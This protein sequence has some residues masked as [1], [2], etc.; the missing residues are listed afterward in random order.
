MAK[1]YFIAVI[2]LIAPL[3]LSLPEDRDE[4][5]EI[6]ADN[7]VINEKESR[8]EYSGAVVVSQGSMILEGDVVNLKTGDS[9]EVEIFVSKGQP[10]R[11][12]N[13]RSKTDSEPVRGRALTI[14]Y[15]YDSDSVVLAGDAIIT[16]ED[17]E[18][19]GQEIIYN[20]YTG[21]I[22]ASGNHSRRVSMTMKPRKK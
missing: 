19:S 3:A 12:E 11:F 13:L 6:T 8:A 22:T 2:W 4:P 5:I 15:S 7:A 16:S 1:C 14:Y 20:L 10:A 18:F 17:S 21:E 9:G